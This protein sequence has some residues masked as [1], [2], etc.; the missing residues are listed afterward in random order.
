[1][2]IQSLYMR[3]DSGSKNM[4]PEATVVVTQHGLLSPAV[5]WVRREE[6]EMGAREKVRR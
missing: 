1:M 6:N 5:I 4:E 3:N 2:I